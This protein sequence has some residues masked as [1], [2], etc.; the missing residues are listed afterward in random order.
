MSSRRAMRFAIAALGISI[1]TFGTSIYFSYQQLIR[2]TSIEVSQ[3]EELD[4]STLRDL[5]KGIESTQS[6]ILI[7][8]KGIKTEILKKN[9]HNEK[10]QQISN[11]DG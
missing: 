8:T 2:P 3:F 6:I 5:L 4:N 11:S 9:V 7:E 1:L 10:I